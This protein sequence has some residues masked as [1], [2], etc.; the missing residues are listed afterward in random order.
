MCYQYFILE[1]RRKG[2]V[3]LQPE[4]KKYLRNI[5]KL[6]LEMTVLEVVITKSGS[7]WE[8]PHRSRG[9]GERDHF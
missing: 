5:P 6:I 3:L 4:K 1:Y 7:L 2:F 8:H 9:M